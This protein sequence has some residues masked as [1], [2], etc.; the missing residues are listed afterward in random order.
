MSILGH[1]LGA[2][3]L[4]KLNLLFKNTQ[5]HIPGNTKSNILVEQTSFYKIKTTFKYVERHHIK[6]IE[7]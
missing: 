7:S 1:I 6:T 2:F 3:N 5:T 4:N